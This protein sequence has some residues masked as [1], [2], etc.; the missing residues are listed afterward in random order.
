MIPV[1]F[2]D[3][4]SISIAVENVNGSR[5]QARQRHQASKRAQLRKKWFLIK[6]RRI[7]VG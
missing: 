7:K 1:S 3:E 6:C 4:K 5:T 2:V